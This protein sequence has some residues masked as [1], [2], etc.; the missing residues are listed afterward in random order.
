[1]TRSGYT[2]GRRPPPKRTRNR[3]VR[4]HLHSPAIA[5]VKARLKF[6]GVEKGGVSVKKNRPR[7]CKWL[8]EHRYSMKP[9]ATHK[10]AGKDGTEYVGLSNGSIVHKDVAVRKG[11]V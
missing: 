10:V 6:F 7:Q 9:E 1:M 8:R 11:L 2:H 3:K 4:R 5:S